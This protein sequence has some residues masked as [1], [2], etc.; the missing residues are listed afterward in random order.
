M[1][2]KAGKIKWFD[3]GKSFGFIIDDDTSEDIYVHGTQVS[4]ESGPLTDGNSVT[5]ELGVHQGKQQAQNVIASKISTENG[6][7]YEFEFKGAKGNHLRQWAFI[8]LSDFSTGKGNNYSSVLPKL[9]EITLDAESDWTFG[10][11]TNTDELEILRSYLCYTFVRLW[12]ERKIAF[13]QDSEGKWASLNTGLVDKLYKPIFVLFRENAKGQAPYK[14]ASFCIPGI[15]YHGKKLISLFDPL[16]ERAE[17][18]SDPRDVFLD[19]NKSIFPQHD[20][21]IEDGI[22]RGRFPIDFLRRNKP[23]EFDWKDVESLDEDARSEFLSELADAITND[24]QCYR[25]II[26]RIDD[27]IRIATERVKWNF[28]TAIPQ[29]YPKFDLMSLLL[30]LALVKDDTVDLALVVQRQH[31]GTYSGNTI[32]PLSWAYK[33]A[34]LVCRPDSDWLTTEV[35]SSPD[36][37][38]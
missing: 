28:K 26:A 14:F 36:E 3:S 9:A 23:F 35:K 25:G 2:R 31:N 38:G 4:P 8:P 1:L 27:A 10:T 7:P 11:G 37:D 12:S 5:F 33:N 32:I 22:R 13:A 16:P 6:D 17:Y 18:F 21:I 15:D 24:D 20:H 19:A 34:R 29:Y 30:P